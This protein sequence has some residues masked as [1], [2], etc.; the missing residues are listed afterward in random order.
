MTI[1]SE[2]LYPPEILKKLRH[3]RPFLRSIANRWVMGWPDRVKAL[4]ESE[5]YWESLE[6]QTE[7]EIDAQMELPEAERMNLAP[8]E[9]NELA[10][11]DPAPPGA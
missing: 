2:S 7:L 9:V 10:G 5:I 6:R 11:I 4:I 8:W 3:A 1:V